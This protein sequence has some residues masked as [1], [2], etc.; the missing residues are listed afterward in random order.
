MPDPG[1]ARSVARLPKRALPIEQ[2]KRAHDS[3]RQC[4]DNLRGSWRK[5][6]TLAD[7]NSS[8]KKLMQQRKWAISCVSYA[9]SVSR[10]V[11]FACKG[12]GVRVP[13]S[14]PTETVILLA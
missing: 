14:P 11:Y 3:I 9:R 7:E 12:S 8:S 1:M 10:V 2:R 5:A 6:R 4:Y 13:P